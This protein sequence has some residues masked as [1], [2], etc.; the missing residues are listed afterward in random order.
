MPLKIIKF[1]KF[2]DKNGALI[3]LSLKDFHN[4]KIKRF[5]ILFGKKDFIRG[6]HAHKKCSQIFIPISGSVKIEVLSKTKKIYNLSQNICKI[7]IVPPMNW[8][9]LKFLKNNSSLLVLCDVKYSEKEYIRDFNVFL[10]KININK[11]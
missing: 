2:I 6:N 5:F 9:K 8:C 11:Y 3:P 10:K 4:F 7:L 1:K